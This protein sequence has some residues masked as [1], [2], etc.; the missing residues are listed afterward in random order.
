MGRNARLPG[1]RAA[2]FAAACGFVVIGCVAAVPVSSAAPS[3]K[4]QPGDA[5]TTGG[6]GQRQAVRLFGVAPG[7]RTFRYQ[8]GRET[9]STYRGAAGLAEALESGLLQPRTMV[10]DDFNGDG[11]ADLAVGYAKD[12]TGVLSLRLGNQQAIAPTDPAVIRAVRDGRYPAPFLPQATL[13]ALPGPAD[14]LE[15]GDFDADGY[16]D[17][18]AASRGGSTLY[19]LRGNGHG[20]FARSGRSTRRAPSQRCGQARSS[21]DA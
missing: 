18:V 13:V 1:R 12:G 16:A 15:A 2:A 6:I 5:Y 14:F 9:P 3:A 8:I 7:R 20:A 17:V 21:S 10:S 11:M 19:L 4:A